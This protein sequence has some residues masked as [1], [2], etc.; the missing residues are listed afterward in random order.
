MKIEF[1]RNFTSRKCEGNTGEA[2]EQEVMSCNEVETVWEFT[3]LGDSVSA[4]GG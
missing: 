2:V 3:Y 1:P 4:G